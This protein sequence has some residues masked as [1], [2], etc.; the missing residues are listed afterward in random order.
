MEEKTLT[1]EERIFEFKET[2]KQLIVQ[3][4]LSPS[5]VEMVVRDIYIDVRQLSEQNLMRILNE[6]KKEVDDNGKHTTV[7]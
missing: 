6:K 2:M 4:N 1:L 5:I 3:S 7:S